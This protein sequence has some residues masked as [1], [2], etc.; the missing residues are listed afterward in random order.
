VEHCEG[1]SPMH[2]C[3]D[4]AANMKNVVRIPQLVKKAPEESF[5]K[6]NGVD[7]GTSSVNCTTNRVGK[8]IYCVKILWI[9]ETG[10]MNQ[11]GSC[12]VAGNYPRCC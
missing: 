6:L 4:Q 5:W 8:A 9:H 11:S 3:A 7:Y 12:T 10:Q 2:K 1:R